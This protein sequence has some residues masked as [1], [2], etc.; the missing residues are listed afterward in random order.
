MIL[1]PAILL[2]VTAGH[3]NGTTDVKTL[4]ESNT[5][6]ALDL[7]HL[8]K[9]DKD[10]LFFSPYSISTALAM[11]YAGAKANTARQMSQV[12]HFTLKPKQLHLAFGDLETRLNALRKKED[13]ELG[14]ANALWAQKDYQFLQQFFDVVKQNYGAELSYADFKTA[15]ESARRE[16]NA[17]VERQT[18]DKIKDLI[19][20]G[21]LSALTRLVLANAIYFKGLWSSQFDESATQST[22]FYLAPNTAVDVPMMRQEHEFNYMEND[23]LQVLELPY[24]GDDLS[25]IILLP[26][27]MDGLT[28]VES[29]LSVESLR[30]LLARLRQR[31]VTVFLPRFKLSSQFSLQDTLASLDM[32]DAFKPGIADFSGMDGTRMLHISA[33]VHKAFVDV[34]EEGTE[35]AAATGVVVRVTSAPAAPT[36]F[37][38][39]HPFIFLIQDNRSGSILFLGKVVDPTK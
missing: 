7:Y 33:V 31:K 36:V 4:V 39:D 27:E 2:S 38:A 10:N 23:N 9:T 8:L 29:S 3:S 17:W 13:I 22:K 37:R 1:V 14:V 34:N 25:M 30:S 20:P 21:V 26:K 5:A 24:V 16:I 32:P 12:L 19:K 11:T 6:F 15:Y 18:N 35:A 28:Q